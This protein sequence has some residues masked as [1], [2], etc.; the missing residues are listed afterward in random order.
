MKTKFNKTEL[1]NV[2]I[3]EILVFTII[4]I[5]SKYVN[6]NYGIGDVFFLTGLVFFCFSVF[7]VTRYLGLFDSTIYSFK[8]LF[9][10]SYEVESTL[11]EYLINNPYSKPFIETLFS[12]LL[13]IVLSLVLK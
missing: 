13:L 8:K 1:R 12:S 2:M 9:S 5:Y 7:R 10:K 6:L 11:Y 3:K 4:F